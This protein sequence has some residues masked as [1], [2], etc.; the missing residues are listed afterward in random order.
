MAVP[1][2]IYIVDY[3]AYIIYMKLTKDDAS[4]KS[5]FRLRYEIVKTLG[6]AADTLKKPCPAFSGPFDRQTSFAKS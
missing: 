6:I 1:N 2:Y 5:R 4:V 3:R